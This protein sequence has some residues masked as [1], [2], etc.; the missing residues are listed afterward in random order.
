MLLMPFSEF[1]KPNYLH[2]FSIRTSY[3]SYLQKE[4]KKIIKIS[5]NLCTH[6]VIPFF[7]INANLTQNLY[8][9]GQDAGAKPEL[10]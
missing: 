3:E 8:K 4:N 5:M 7:S 1:V 10:S 9:T 2:S 6:Q